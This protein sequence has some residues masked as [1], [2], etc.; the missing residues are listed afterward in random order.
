[1]KELHNWSVG[2]NPRE[3]TYSMTLFNYDERG[4]ETD[5]VFIDLT[6][7]DIQQIIKALTIMVNA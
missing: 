2:G 6:K 4:D 1:M 5:S 7:E 3:N